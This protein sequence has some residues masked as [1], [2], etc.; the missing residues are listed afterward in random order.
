[1]NY[2]ANVGI[3]CLSEVIEMTAEQTRDII[4]SLSKSQGFYGR[5]YRDITENRTTEE[6]DEIF[7]ELGKDCKDV[8]DLIFKL[9]G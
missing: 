6:A 2:V 8:L 7:E 9:E 5:L 3:K 4:L 1:M